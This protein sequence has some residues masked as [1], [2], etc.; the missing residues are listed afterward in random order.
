MLFSRLGSLLLHLL[1]RTA[2][3]LHEADLPVVV[4]DQVL[5]GEEASDVRPHRDFAGQSQ[6]FGGRLQEG[7]LVPEQRE[8]GRGY[9]ALIKVIT[10][11]LIIP[12]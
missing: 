4:P 6:S 12:W 3:V 9:G 7:H 10:E 1:V 2:I 5:Q 8:D 11:G